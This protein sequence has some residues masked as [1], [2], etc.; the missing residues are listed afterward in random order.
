MGQ[1]WGQQLVIAKKHPAG[2]FE[3]EFDTCRLSLL[4]TLYISTQHCHRRNS[5][6]GTRHQANITEAKTVI[7]A[8]D[9]SISHSLDTRAS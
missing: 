2:P 5:E 7:S 6:H 1:R 4:P 8:R 9:V 3:F